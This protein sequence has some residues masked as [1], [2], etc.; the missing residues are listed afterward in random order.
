MNQTARRTTTKPT[1]HGKYMDFTTIFNDN[2]KNML[3]W[4]AVNLNSIVKGNINGMYQPE[5][6]VVSS[7]HQKN[8]N[9]KLN[10]LL[11]LE[12]PNCCY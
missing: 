9:K 7:S 6:S 8:K 11:L 3:T 1:M 4:K 10:L 12:I 5:T 2:Q